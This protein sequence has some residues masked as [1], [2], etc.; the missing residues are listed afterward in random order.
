MAFLTIA[1]EIRNQIIA[2]ATSDPADVTKLSIHNRRLD[3]ISSTND[4]IDISFWNGSLLFVCKQLR[5]E[6]RPFLTSSIEWHFR[7]GNAVDLSLST[8]QHYFDRTVAVELNTKFNLDFPV[9]RFRTLEQLQLRRTDENKAKLELSENYTEAVQQ[10]DRCIGDLG[11]VSRAKDML[12]ERQWI[13]HFS[14]T[15]KESSLSKTPSI[16]KVYGIHCR[17]TRRRCW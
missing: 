17:R 7:Q 10:I 12:L 9:S 11:F 13:K 16:L 3:E 1:S 15:L 8:K 6:V 4:P 5:E 2:L 14:G